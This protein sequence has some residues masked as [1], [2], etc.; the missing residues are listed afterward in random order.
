MIGIN[1]NDNKIVVLFKNRAKNGKSEITE[2]YNGKVLSN[3]KPLDLI[4]LKDLK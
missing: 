1:E 2:Y 3:G 4:D